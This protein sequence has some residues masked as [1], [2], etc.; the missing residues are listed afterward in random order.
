MTHRLRAPRHLKEP[1][2]LFPKYTTPWKVP[3]QRQLQLRVTPYHH[4]QMIRG[5]RKAVKNHCCPEDRQKLQSEPTQWKPSP[6]RSCQTLLRLRTAS[7]FELEGH[8]NQRPF[9][10]RGQAVGNLRKGS[11]YI[12]SQPSRRYRLII[13]VHP[14]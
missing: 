4:R 5:S 8:S 11:N 7:H 14:S 1:H 10:C 12:S 9:F 6:F 3:Q 13:A 2:P